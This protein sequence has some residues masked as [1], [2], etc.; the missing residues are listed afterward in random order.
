M[1]AVEHNNGHPPKSDNR[2]SVNYAAVRTSVL[3]FVK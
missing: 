1:L 3:N 2:S